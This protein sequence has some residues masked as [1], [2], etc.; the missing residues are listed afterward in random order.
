MSNFI[1][2]ID[3]TLRNFELEPDIDP[4]LCEYLSK[5]KKNNNLYIVT[6]RTYNNFKNF[7]LELSNMTTKKLDV[8]NMFDVVICED[9]HLCYNKDGSNCLV[10]G[11]SVEQLNKIMKFIDVHLNMA[12]KK[13]D[14]SLPHQDLISEVT[15]TIQELEGRGSFKESLE[16]F[17]RQNNLDKLRVNTLTHN[18]LSISVVGVGKHSAIDYYPLN[19]SDAYYFCDERN[20]MELAIKIKNAGGNVVCPS[21]AIDEIKDIANYVSDLPYSYGIVDYLS[22]YF[23]K[24]LN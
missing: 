4:N 21:N 16:D 19:L 14:I 3:G 22:R 12:N 1:F 24:S 9:G 6:G 10:D 17:I 23:K 2:D 18:R 8:E 7:V 13:Y 15:I 5:L 11:A 20:D